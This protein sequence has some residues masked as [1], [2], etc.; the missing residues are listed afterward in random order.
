[1]ADKVRDRE[2]SAT[3]GPLD[4]IHLDRRTRP[5][6][7]NL[8]IID[9]EMGIGQALDAGRDRV[10]RHYAEGGGRGS[11]EEG[12]QS[13]RRVGEWEYSVYL[14]RCVSTN[15]DGWMDRHCN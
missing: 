4:A 15:M 9:Q 5:S 3:S 10:W 7:D 11:E 2:I 13:G 8:L 6:R 14:Y 12:V 1:M